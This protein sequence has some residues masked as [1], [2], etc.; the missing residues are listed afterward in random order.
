MF[1]FRYHVVSLAA[2]FVALVVFA[3]AALGAVVAAIAA[4]PALRHLFELLAR[5]LG[6]GG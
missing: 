5:Q 3:V 6:L 2:V 1:T 4:S